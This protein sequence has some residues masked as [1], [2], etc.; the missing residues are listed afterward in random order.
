MPTRS[1]RPSRLT[2]LLLVVLTTLLLTSCG[3]NES[4]AAGG[5]SPAEVMASAKKTL[6]ETSGVNLSLTTSDLPDGV[7]GL[8]KATGVG[9]H[10]P[11]FDGTITVV[12]SGN[13]FNV[14][15]IAVGGKVYAQIPL[16]PGWQD[17]DPGEYG[18]PDPAQLMSPDS[19]F[20]SLLTATTGVEKGDSIRGGSD[21][22]EILTEYSGTVSDKTVKNVIP[23]AS[24]DFVASYTISDSGELREA[25]LTG[26]FYPDSDSMTYT[27]GFDDY[28]T[29]KDISAP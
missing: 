21:N 3:G 15:V 22:S 26:V 12:L 8:T 27:I 28:G 18:A 6:D 23:T 7:T 10:A 11:A 29:E 17:V 20:S 5:K 14:P 19:G 1:T 16:T 2:A 24:G 25:R 9:T 4:S 13:V